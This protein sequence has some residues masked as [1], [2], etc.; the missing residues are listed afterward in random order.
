[1]MNSKDVIPLSIPEAF[2][3]ESVSQLSR[4]HSESMSWC[5][6]PVCDYFQSSDRTCLYASCLSV[7]RVLHNCSSGL[8][9]EGWLLWASITDINSSSLFGLQLKYTHISRMMSIIFLMDVILQECTETKFTEWEL[10]CV[11]TAI[12]AESRIRFWSPDFSLR[13]FDAPS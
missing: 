9:F 2:A 1:M 8:R 11:Y 7:Q 4:K 13:V 12:G 5:K 6:Q 10:Q 3:L